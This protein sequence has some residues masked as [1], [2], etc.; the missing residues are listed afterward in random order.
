MTVAILASSHN[1][2]SLDP[3]DRVTIL[4]LKDYPGAQENL[5]SGWK[6]KRFS[7]FDPVFKRITAEVSKD[8]KN[9][10]CAKGAPNVIL[11][12]KNFDQDVVE[13]Y[14]D[15]AGIFAKKGFRSLGVAVKEEG[16][17]WD[18]LGISKCILRT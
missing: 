16:K 13:A 2:K 5:R 15:Q 8:G 6:T 14:R 12:L 1:V 4:T 18:L 11:K 3:I 9:Y 17:D 7:P 10:T